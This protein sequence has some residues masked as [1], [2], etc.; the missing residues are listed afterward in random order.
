M[1]RISTFSM[2]D[3]KESVAAVPDNLIK[4][5]GYRGFDFK[6]SLESRMAGYVAFPSGAANSPG[7]NGGAGMDCPAWVQPGIAQFL[8]EPRNFRVDWG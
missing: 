8:Y 4:D 5:L 2:N 1:F 7:S 6:D 3:L